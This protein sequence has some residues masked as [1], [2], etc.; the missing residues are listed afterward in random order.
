MHAAIQVADCVSCT[1]KDLI[2]HL[3]TTLSLL[4]INALDPDPTSFLNASC[5]Y[6]PTDVSYGID[7]WNRFAS[8]PVELTLDDCGDPVYM[9]DCPG[10]SHE[11]SKFC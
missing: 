4:L 9:S 3:F 10:I 7:G 1:E 5:P 6:G 11:D 8:L 2:C